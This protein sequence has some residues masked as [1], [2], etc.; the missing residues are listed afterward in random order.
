MDPYEEE[1]EARNVDQ[2]DEFD[3]AE[4]LVSREQTVG[5]LDC[6]AVLNVERNVCSRNAPAGGRVRSCFDSRP[7]QCS[8]EDLKNAYRRLCLT[9]HP[10]KHHQPED[11]VS[12]QILIAIKLQ[13]S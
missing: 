3:Q 11:K 8:D 7:R 5:A 1:R 4:E 10:D 2:M 12:I 9:F 13:C 6:Y